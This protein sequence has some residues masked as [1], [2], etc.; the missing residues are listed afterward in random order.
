M[1]VADGFV[2]KLRRLVRPGTGRDELKRAQRQIAVAQKQLAHVHNERDRLQERVTVLQQRL[3]EL[4]SDVAACRIDARRNRRR[5]LSAAVLRDLLK[6]RAAQL[7]WRAAAPNAPIRESHL[8]AVSDAYRRA[9]AESPQHPPVGAYARELD[10]L[11]WWVPVG[12]GESE[13][14]ESVVAKEALPY[15]AL[16][17]AREVCTGGVMLDLGAH[18]GG[19]AIPRVLL[20]DVEAVYCAEP[21]PLNYACLVANVVH[22]GVRGF[23]LP[24]QVAIGSANGSAR[25]HRTKASRGHRVIVAEQAE[26]A[27]LIEVRVR[28]L[29]TWVEELSIDPRSVSFVKSDIQGYELH[30]LMGAPGLLAQPQIAWQLEIA[31]E[32]L[33]LAGS[34]PHDLLQLLQ[35]QFTHF[36]DLNVDAPGKRRRPVSVL[37]DALAYLDQGQPHTDVIMY[38]SVG[39]GCS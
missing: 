30:M 14:V 8:L 24:D 6:A 18:D 19:T 20:G 1:T 5:S 23:V 33:R 17:H 2:G 36:I 16:L 31:P 39:A 11:S 4:E 21:D 13:W 9:V 12:A 28:R 3:E 37:P 22:N 29:D 38:R 15:R 27:E 34:D 35:R 25:L 32:L 26:Q 7:P 10:G